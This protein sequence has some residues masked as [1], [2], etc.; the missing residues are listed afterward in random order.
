MTDPADLLKACQHAIRDLGGVAAS[1]ASGPADLP[2]RAGTLMRDPLT[3]F[4]STD[5][6][7]TAENLSSA[8]TAS[9]LELRVVAEPVARRSGRDGA[10]G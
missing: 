2:E 1:L 10:R 4:R 3:T 5:H 6:E 7:A 9:P 8:C